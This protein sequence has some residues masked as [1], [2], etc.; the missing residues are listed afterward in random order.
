MAI[1]LNALWDFG[2]PA[3]SEQRFVAALEGAST[4]DA[5]ILQT[6]IAR[7]YGIRRD[8]G[9]AQ[10]IL[11]SIQDQALSA[12]PEARVRY[13]LE[14]GRTFASATH[15]AETQTA[16]ALEAARTLF[17]R[18]FD[19]A[20]AS[21]LDALAIDALHMM[22]FVDKEPVDQ[23]AWDMRALA[24]SEDSSQPDAKAWEGSLRNNVGYA[25]HLMGRYEEAIEQFGHSLMAHQ[26]A[27]QT[28][29]VRV[30]QWM[31][32]WTYRAQERY[33][34]A[35]EIQLRLERE[36]DETGEPDPFVYEELAH[37]YRALGDVERAE[38][39]AEKRRGLEPR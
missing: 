31:I 28:R 32:A 23:L 3:V 2:K 24:H 5:L 9:R 35:L 36:W 11:A 27:G 18:A 7:T 16:E 21:E 33:P 25:L 37:L 14:L 19:A 20:R 12:S 1:D 10:E 22:A 13:L 38:Y 15:A 39:Y 26:R 30:A 29:S 34:E 6:Q 4:E 17:L 8:F